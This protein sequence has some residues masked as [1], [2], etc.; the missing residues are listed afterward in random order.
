MFAM[1]SPKIPSDISTIPPKNRIA[2]IM[3]VKPSVPVM[4]KANLL[5]NATIIATNAKNEMNNPETVKKRSGE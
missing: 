3:I 2:I 5:I 4:P 1:Y